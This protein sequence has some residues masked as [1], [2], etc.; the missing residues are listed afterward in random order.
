MDKPSGQSL[1][2]HLL[3]SLLVPLLVVLMLGALGA[4]VLARGIGTEVHDNWL[5]DSA[6][7]LSEQI[8]IQ[9]GKIRLDISNSAIQMFE[10]DKADLIF[11]EVISRKEGKI[12]RTARFPE[13]PI[14]LTANVPQFYDNVINGHPVRIV[15]VL[16]ELPDGHSDDVVVQVAET[17]LKRE[18]LTTRILWL[19]VPLELIILALAGFV[20]WFAITSS[21]RL[22]NTVG[23]RL[24]NYAPD[25]L[26]PVEDGFAPAE[27]KPFINSIN[28][29]I[30]KL[31]ESQATQ[32]R[33]IA[34]A[35]HQLRTPLATL[36]V[37]TERALRE[38]DPVRHSEALSH[39]LAA[40]KRLSRLTKQLLALARSNASP[41]MHEMVDVDLAELVK[42]ELVRWADKAIH[43]D[44]DLGYAGP[45]C[46]VHIRGDPLLLRELLGNLVDNAI[47]Y[48]RPGGQV[49]VSLA[50]APVTL[51]V[52]DDG[53][54]IPPDERGLVLEP[55]YRLRGSAGDGSGLG[56]AIA[57]DIAA[58]HGLSLT[59]QTPP[60]GNGT[61]IQVEPDLLPNGRRQDTALIP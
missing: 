38:P 3:V 41:P 16:I 26:A 25:G 34:S 2:R 35:A 45:E 28:R 33:F 42:D 7:S 6:M 31:A 36:Q 24:A 20:T 30:G 60:Q 23:E 54:G 29:L 46:G 21:L 18:S 19:A 40:L 56:L 51:T 61:R 1:R 11:E 12:Y 57:R 17:K 13:P 4:F 59:I 5:Y 39:V 48:G 27:I 53:A 43:L 22:V 47:R 50:A 10:W 52:D 44:M 15:A 32:R 9:E 49:T 58:R 8:K 55:F 14:D 37:Q